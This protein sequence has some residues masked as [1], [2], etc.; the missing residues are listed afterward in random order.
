MLLLLLLSVIV[1]AADAVAGAASSTATRTSSSPS[2]YGIARC[3]RSSH[4][5]CRRRCCCRG[6]GCRCRRSRGSS[7]HTPQFTHH[8]FELCF[9]SASFCLWS[10]IFSLN[11]LGFVALVPPPPVAGLLALAEFPVVA[12]SQST[13]IFN[14]VCVC[15]FLFLLS[16]SVFLPSSFSFS[17]THSLLLTLT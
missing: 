15:Y 11:F 1:G 2:T 9:S 10:A 6:D 3:F 13:K 12:I 4:T 16:L 8:L 7:C 17:L 14:K 5:C